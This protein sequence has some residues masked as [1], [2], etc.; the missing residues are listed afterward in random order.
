MIKTN[1]RWP[2]GKSRMTKTLFD[3]MPQKVNKY[4]DV[5][6]GGG[7]VLLFILQ[8]YKPNKTIANDIDENLINFYQYLITNSNDLVNELHKIKKSYNSDEFR[9]KFKELNLNK[10]IDFFIA[11]KTSFSG[12]N[13]N[14]SKH[15]YD[16]NFTYKSIDKLIDLSILYNKTEFINYDFKLFNKPL[17]D[18][19]IYIDPPYYSNSKKGLYG[20]KGELHKYFNHNNL[21]KFV[22]KY[23]NDN[24]IMISYDNCSNITEM[25]DSYNIHDFEFIYSMTNSGGNKCKIGKELIITNY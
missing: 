8:K 24:K 18:Y 7:S 15:A 20:D 21:K 14:Y 22:D 10:P 23:S 11:N 6:I 1:L 13:K 3:F 16:N 19:F 2:G 17:K 9:D 4:F 12:L 5:F 25:Y